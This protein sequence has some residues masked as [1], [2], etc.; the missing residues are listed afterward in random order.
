MGFSTQSPGHLLLLHFGLYFSVISGF[1][2]G[3]LFDRNTRAPCIPVTDRQSMGPGPAWVAGWWMCFP[4]AMLSADLT[5]MSPRA[6]SSGLALPKM[7]TRNWPPASCFRWPDRACPPSPGRGHVFM[8]VHCAGGRASA[9]PFLRL[10]QQHYS[11]GSRMLPGTPHS[12]QL[13]SSSS[14]RLFLHS[15]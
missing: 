8:C 12:L 10:Q 9:G 14:S 6:A 7:V 3:I 5:H 15:C 4:W 2:D 11:A 13:Q 1:L